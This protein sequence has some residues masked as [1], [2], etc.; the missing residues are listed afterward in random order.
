MPA[1]LK[2]H[3]ALACKRLLEILFP[4][5][6]H[7]QR[8]V[9]RCCSNFSEMILVCR[10][11]ESFG[12]VLER[13]ESVGMSG[14]R[15]QDWVLCWQVGELSELSE[16]SSVAV[17]IFSFPSPLIDCLMF[18]SEE[19]SIN[20]IKFSS[21]GSKPQTLSPACCEGSWWSWW[22]WWLCSY[23][24]FSFDCLEQK[25]LCWE[26]LQ[27]SGICWG[28]LVSPAVEDKIVIVP[29][30]GWL[31]MSILIRLWCAGGGETEDCSCPVCCITASVLDM[32]D[33]GASL[34]FV[35]NDCNRDSS[36]VDCEQML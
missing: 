18:L 16:I 2:A 21:A 7:A 17:D 28:R 22:S 9:Q 32:I 27:Q 13:E 3:L 35:P 24:C 33:I 20:F 12:E 5:F 26:Q 31:F 10:H 19:F 36:L 1:F 25:E 23:N 29:S 30:S 4:D 34:S 14:G 11:V 8:H 15:G 6:L